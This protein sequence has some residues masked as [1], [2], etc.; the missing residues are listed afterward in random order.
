MR[1]PI[2]KPEPRVKIPKQLQRKTPLLPY[3]VDK[4][5]VRILSPPKAP[6]PKA[7]QEPPQKAIKIINKNSWRHHKDPMWE[8]TRKLWFEYYP[9]TDG[10]YYQCALCP[11]MVHRKE[12]TLD[13]IETRSSRPDLK[14]VLSN[15]QP[16]HYICNQR[17]GSL[18]LELYWR[19]YPLGE[20]AFPVN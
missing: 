4:N 14:Y 5:G 11:Y 20:Y 19:A 6:K 10:E 8:I 7:L 12:T 18:S 13:H 9:P 2:P 16:A 1:A 15:L 3:R 17:R